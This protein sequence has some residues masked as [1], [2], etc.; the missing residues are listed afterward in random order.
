M[1]GS[2]DFLLLSLADAS[3]LDDSYENDGPPPLD[4]ISVARSAFS[5]GALT[6]DL[7]EFDRE[8][9]DDAFTVW[10]VTE[11]G[12]IRPTRHLAAC[13]RRAC[14]DG[15]PIG[16]PSQDDGERVTADPPDLA[17]RLDGGA[18]QE[19]A[20]QQAL[21]AQLS[22][23][24]SALEARCRDLEARLIAQQVLALSTVQIG[25]NPSMGDESA[26]IILSSSLYAKLKGNLR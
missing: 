16:D 20:G 12:T 22:Q 14:A 6:R 2:P 8:A 25:F 4:R 9:L 10:A 11:V 1:T 3:Y 5:L 23:S 19:T 17:E 7:S 15:C 21:I 24:L 13:R 26:Q 18:C